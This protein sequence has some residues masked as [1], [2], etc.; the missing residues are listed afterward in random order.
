MEEPQD[1]QGLATAQRKQ[2]AKSCSLRPEFPRLPTLPTK[3]PAPALGHNAR[4][5]GVCVDGMST[6]ATIQQTQT[7]KFGED[8][9]NN[10]RGE[11]AQEDKGLWGHH[12]AQL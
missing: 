10:Q 11:R 7:L 6:P 8:P 2:P 12:P 5:G 9:L 1:T 4:R 3:L